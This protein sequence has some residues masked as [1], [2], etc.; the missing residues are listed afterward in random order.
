MES[1]EKRQRYEKVGT[2]LEALFAGYA[3]PV[4]RMATMA[5]VLFH[6]FE[7]YSWCGFYLQKG[8]G[9]IVG[10]Y[11]G[12]VACLEIP[13]GKGVCGAVA[14]GGGALVVENVH[15]FPGHIA[16]DAGSMSEVVVP[17]RCSN[18]SV[19]GVLDVDSYEVAAFCEVDKVEL[20]TLV[21]RYLTPLDWR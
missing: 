6:E 9:L 2:K 14:A 7:T 8:E 16:C 17:I 4:L 3:D 5:A 21:E 1:V 13:V 10:P 20:Q 11:Q 19:V 12:K 15:E 18:S